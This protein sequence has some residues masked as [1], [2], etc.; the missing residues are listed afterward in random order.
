[1]VD[2]A[3]AERNNSEHPMYALIRS[4]PD[5]FNGTG[6]SLVSQQSSLLSVVY[7][8]AYHRQNNLHDARD[9]RFV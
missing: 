5:Y 8:F 4:R 3:V 9:D 2:H 1:M 7:A 6:F